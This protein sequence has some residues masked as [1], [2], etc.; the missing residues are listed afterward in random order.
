MTCTRATTHSVLDQFVRPQSRSGV[1]HDPISG[2]LRAPE[3]TRAQRHWSRQQPYL[4]RCRC[5]IAAGPSVNL[6]SRDVLNQSSMCRERTM[7]YVN[8]QFIT[9]YDSGLVD[10]S[11]VGNYG[12][13]DE[14]GSVLVHSLYGAD[15]AAS[16]A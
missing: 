4:A 5:C 2:T 16:L 11:Q 7:R 13:I 1:S 9:P 12:V 14:I 10:H 6:D 8:A 3:L 15:T